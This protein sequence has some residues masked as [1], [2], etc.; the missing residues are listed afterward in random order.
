MS[1]INTKIRINPQN[2]IIY[3]LLVLCLLSCNTVYSTC[4]T[5][6][7]RFPE[8][9]CFFLLVLVMMN[10]KH[11][12][13][14]I[15]TKWLLIFIPYYLLNIIIIFF[16]VSTDKIIS[17]SVRFLIFVPFLTL[18][19]LYDAHR[20][21]IWNIALKFENLVIFYA[22]IS[23]I[24]WILV[25]ILNIIPATG[26]I[27]ISWGGEKNYPLYFGIFTTRQVQE[28]FGRVWIRNQG[29]FTEGPMYNLVLVIAV[30]IEVFIA[31]LKKKTGK[32]LREGIDL[33]KIVILVIADISTFT[34][35]G[36]I[37]LIAIA[38]FKYCL[39]PSKSA[40][41]GI[42]KWLGAIVVLILASY[43][44]NKLFLIKADTG[45]WEVRFD[46]FLAGYNAWKNNIWFGNGYDTMDAITHYMSSRRSYNM[47]YS[48]GLFSILAQGGLVLTLNYLIGFCGYVIYSLKNHR[49][50][51]IAML[52]IVILVLITSIFHYTFILL[53]LLAYGY[54]LLF[55]KTF[56]MKKIG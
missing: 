24:L 41:V 14:R 39:M 21:N 43:V 10:I 1:K 4:V 53:L 5:K 45:S 16:S 54:A 56:K 35:T 26:E 42:M 33:R 22:S 20:N 2:I 55:N 11:L 27:V 49:Y 29:F 17:Y 52:I 25:G 8:L 9:T 51:L 12:S 46:D 40:L 7:Y 37:L 3:I 32:Y 19:I 30:C 34:V 18:V 44:A 47:G 28:F 36:M 38:A 31:P 23:I 50:E 13:Y 6:D 15:I 48:S